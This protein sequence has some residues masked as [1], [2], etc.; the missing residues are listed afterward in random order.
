MQLNDQHRRHKSLGHWASS[1]DARRWLEFPAN[2]LERKTKQNGWEN[3]RWSRGLE[4]RNQT[5]RAKEKRDFVKRANAICYQI[6]MLQATTEDGGE[7]QQQD[8]KGKKCVAQ[9]Y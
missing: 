5:E 2:I 1:W 6:K 8:P 9:I 7:Q 4:I 3:R